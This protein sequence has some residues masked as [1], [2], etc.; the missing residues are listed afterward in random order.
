MFYVLGRF[1]QVLSILVFLY[2]VHLYQN[3]I[4]FCTVVR[5]HSSK[6]VHQVLKVLTCSHSLNIFYE[7]YFKVCLLLQI[8]WNELSQVIKSFGVCVRVRVHDLCD[9]LVMCT[10]FA[11]MGYGKGKKRQYRIYLRN[12]NIFFFP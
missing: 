11:R 12:E 5:C 2:I 7:K 3:C 9:L 6:Q 10:V 1:L 4:F 8:M